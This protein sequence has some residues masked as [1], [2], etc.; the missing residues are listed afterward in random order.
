MVCFNHLNYFS[1]N[2]ELSWRLG[3][4]NLGWRLKSGNLGI[5]VSGAMWAV[6]LGDGACH[7]KHRKTRGHKQQAPGA[8]LAAGAGLTTAP[9]RRQRGSRLL[10][11]A[12][13]G[14]QRKMPTGSRRTEAP[15]APKKEPNRRLWYLFGLLDSCD[16]ISD[17]RPGRMWR[18]RRLV[19][20]FLRP[21]WCLRPS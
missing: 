7:Q 6:L 20:Y 2:L 9:L 10:A 5:L 19:A 4:T 1:L 8:V 13:D 3:L 12:S 17:S 16:A 18:H 21:G 14:S 11:G 15:Q